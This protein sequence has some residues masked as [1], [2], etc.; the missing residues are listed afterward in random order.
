MFRD[1]DALTSIKI[2]NRVIS[3]GEGA[4]WDC[5]GLT[6]ITIPNNVTSIDDYAFYG[7]IYL[8]NINFDGTKEQWY[9]IK[10][11]LGWNW[12]DYGHIGYFSVHCID[13]D[14]ANGESW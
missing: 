13:G 8:R 7:C 6:S 1:C 14:I 12:C 10:K 11:G 9:A 3:I 2:G 4:F 5:S